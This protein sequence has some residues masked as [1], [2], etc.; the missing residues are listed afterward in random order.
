MLRC[1]YRHCVRFYEEADSTVACRSQFP[2]PVLLSYDSTQWACRD[3]LV[4]PTQ[5]L[6]GGI[7]RKPHYP[8]E[9]EVASDILG[10]AVAHNFQTILVAQ[11]IRT[12]LQASRVRMKRFLLPF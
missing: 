1:V 9:P 7:T 2:L 5:S 11:S 3:A 4:K 6:E 8:R 10:D 12:E